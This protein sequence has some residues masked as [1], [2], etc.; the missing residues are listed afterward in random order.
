LRIYSPAKQAKDQDPQGAY[1]RRWV[2]EFGSAD[3]PAPIVD[4]KAALAEAKRQMYGLRQ[5]PEARQEAGAIQD[6]HG[7]RRS[8]LPSTASRR[9][10]PATQT[11]PKKG[12][13]DIVSPKGQGQLF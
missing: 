4:E 1:V 13:G 12:D 3:Y 7:S 2:P 9:K 8:G 5:T 6:R 10:Q 11:H